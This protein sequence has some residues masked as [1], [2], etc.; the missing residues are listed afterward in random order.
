LTS[1]KRTA[2]AAVPDQ[3]KPLI[4]PK[5]VLIAVALV[6]IAVVGI[7]GLVIMAVRNPAHTET[8]RD[9]AI[10]A[11]A[12]ES[13]L[14]GLGLLVLIVQ[15]A[16]LANMLEFEIKP[17]LLNTADTTV[18]TVRG[19]ASFVSERMVSPII[20]ASGY[21]SGAARLVGALRGLAPGGRGG[22]SEEQR[23]EVSQQSTRGGER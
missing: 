16:R 20:K 5:Y 22:E 9:M 12:A 10:I 18:S 13:G 3:A 8:V 1:E 23:Q 7:V 17:I 4:S 21:M 11:L 14:I 19:T 6:I 15:V 2:D